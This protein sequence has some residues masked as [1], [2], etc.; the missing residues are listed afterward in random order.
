MFVCTGSKWNGLNV[1]VK[2][3]AVAA[4]D[5]INWKFWFRFIAVNFTQVK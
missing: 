5:D 2:L 4:L 3:L 1:A